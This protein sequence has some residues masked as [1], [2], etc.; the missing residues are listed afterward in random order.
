M[1]ERQKWKKEQAVKD[2]QP[3]QTSTGMIEETKSF[4]DTETG[5][6]MA[7]AHEKSNKN[8]LMMKTGLLKSL[9]FRKIIRNVGY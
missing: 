4:K 2:D 3:S 8:V 1:A 9:I 5:F 6:K 7:V